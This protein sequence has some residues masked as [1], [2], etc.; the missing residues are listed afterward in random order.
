MKWFSG[1]SLRER[2]MVLLFLGCG[3]LLWIALAGPRLRTGWQLLAASRAEA[4]VRQELTARLESGRQ[5]L[6]TLRQ[7]WPAERVL[8]AED[9]V[10]KIETIT[11]GL[12]LTAEPTAV[13]ELRR[14]TVTGEAKALAVAVQAYRQLREVAP[15][16]CVTEVVLT[17]A[18]T[19]GQVDCRISLEGYFPAAAP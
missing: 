19:E 17:A 4:P 15:N 12:R 18:P 3:V 6:E 5:R 2:V 11:A 14:W 10:K 7:A 16:L 13:P 8:G 9:L 1:R